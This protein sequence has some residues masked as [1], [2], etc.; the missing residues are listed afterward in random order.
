MV[1]REEKGGEGS[2]PLVSTISSVP[3]AKKSDTV[4]G[5]TS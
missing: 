3:E 5:G 1:L 2:K 4:V